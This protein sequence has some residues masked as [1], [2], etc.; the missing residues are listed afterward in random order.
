[1]VHYSLLPVCSDI[2]GYLTHLEWGNTT[3][4]DKGLRDLRRLPRGAIAFNGT[5]QHLLRLLA[6][7]RLA[8]FPA[9]LGEVHVRVWSLEELVPIMQELRG[10]ATIRVLSV[11]CVDPEDD[12]P[13]TNVTVATNLALTIRSLPAL[14]ELYIEDLQLARCIHVLCAAIKNCRGLKRL[15]LAGNRISATRS[16][17]WAITGLPSLVS[18]NLSRNCLDRTVHLLLPHVGILTELDLRRVCRSDALV[19]IANICSAFVRE[20]GLVFNSY[21]VCMEGRLAIGT[22]ELTQSLR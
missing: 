10:S 4:C 1:M 21:Q 17:V 22:C 12:R 11:K 18:L 13:C 9:R 6:Q 16:V 19:T 20:G 8:P 7:L 14:E 2:F 15:S 3:Q 5:G